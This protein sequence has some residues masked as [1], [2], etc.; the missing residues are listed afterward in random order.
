VTNRP[1][2]DPADDASGFTARVADLTASAKR[3]GEDL[4]ERVPLARTGVG[5]YER[6]SYA[7][8]TLLGSALALR[9]FLFFIPMSL[10]LVGVAGLVGRYSSVDSVA[11][12]VRVGGQLAKE[13][14]AALDQRTIT[15]WLATIT[16]LIGMAWAGRSLTRALVLSSALSWQ[17]GGRQRLPPRIIG[18]V[19]GLIVGIG[20]AFSIV[21]RIREAT[22]TAV[23]SISF[24]VIAGVYVVLWTVLYLNLPRATS[25]P[26]AALPGSLLVAAV[27]AG[28]Q[29]VTQIYL[30]N[31][32]SEASSIYG[33]FGAVAALLGWFFVL[34]RTLAFSFALNAV[35]FEIHGSVSRLV[36]GLPVLRILPRRSAA[37]A[38]YFDLETTTANDDHPTDRDE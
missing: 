26:G 32:I 23:T 35:V 21:N 8:G 7:A 36:F 10:F 4:L 1:P 38:R 27:L 2:D 13:I 30:P 24:L 22:G 25:D 28:L 11:E 14:D 12:T 33:A 19:V 34:G 9:L 6:D 29:A 31:Q 18:V 15:P 5:V 3:R 37:L 20:L 16:G 17:M